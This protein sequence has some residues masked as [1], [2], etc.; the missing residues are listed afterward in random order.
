MGGWNPRK[1]EEMGAEDVAGKLPCR[2]VIQIRKYRYCQ[3]TADTARSGGVPQF[4]DCSL[5]S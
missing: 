4:L 3:N 1:K 5:V 2:M